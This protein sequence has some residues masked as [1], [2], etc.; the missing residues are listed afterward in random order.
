[1]D[2]MESLHC[3]VLSNNALSW[4]RVQSVG[5]F[6]GMYVVQ[7]PVLL[8][9]ATDEHEKHVPVPIKMFSF[10]HIIGMCLLSSHE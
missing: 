7:F 8:F 5:L 3:I 2:T 9:L 1:M 4:S 10:C 6:V